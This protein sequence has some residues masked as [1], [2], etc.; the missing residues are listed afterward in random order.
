MSYLIALDDGHGMETSGKRT[1]YIESLG[2]SIREN[3]FNKEVIKYLDVELKRCGFDTLLV[4]P[5]DKDKPLNQRTNLANKE[6]ADAY[7]S[8]HFNAYDAS[9]SGA[10]PSGFSLHIYPDSDGGRKLADSILKYLKKGT[11]QNNRGIKE[12]NFHVLRETKMPALLSENGFMDNRKEALLMVNQDFQ[13]EV[14]KEHA[15]GL[16]DYFGVDYVKEKIEENNSDD[17]QLHRVQ[18]GAFKH[19]DNA[20]SLT[21]ELEKD[22]FDTYMVKDSGL[23]KVQVGAYSKKE[24]ADNMANKLEKAGFN[25]YI[26][27]QSGEPVSASEPKKEQ[28]KKEEKPKKETIKKGSKVKVEKGAKSYEGKG[29]ASFVYNNTYSVLQV[30]GDRIVLDDIMT[31][32]HKDN[33]NLVS[34]GEEKSKKKEVKVGSTVKVKNGANSYDGTSLADF[35]YKNEYEVIQLSGNRAVLDDI[36]TAVNKNDLEVI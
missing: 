18:T 12:N 23:Y 24:N 31:A 29:L 14:A 1:P 32:V 15:K 10:N 7:V 5:T 27:K 28:P 34:K 9:F 3:E 21:E 35:V 6:N 11:K 25:V 19:K 33:L 26:T 8:V 16:C 2:R 30:S 22:G 4:A 13:K 36:M 17:G 20:V